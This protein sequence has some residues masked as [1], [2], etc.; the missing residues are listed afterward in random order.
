MA[1]PLLATGGSAL[2]EFATGVDSKADIGARPVD[3]ALAWRASAERPGFSG[4][5]G[6]PHRLLFEYPV[7][8]PGFA[9]GPI[10]IPMFLLCNI[11][12]GQRLT[13]CLVAVHGA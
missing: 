7:T 10:F 9:L 1:G 4:Q 6:R 2:R 11:A 13:R 12:P 3:T 8:G 5:G